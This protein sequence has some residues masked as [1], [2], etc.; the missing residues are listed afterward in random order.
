MLNST[1]NSRKHQFP[2]L[3]WGS[4]ITLDAL[5]FEDTLEDTWCPN[6]SILCSRRSSWAA[7]EPMEL[8]LTSC[9][10]RSGIFETAN[11]STLLVDG[12]LVSPDIRMVL[13]AGMED[14]SGV[15]DLVR[16]VEEDADVRKGEGFRFYGVSEPRS[17]P[18]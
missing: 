8:R 1:S 12:S 18:R 15:G 4:S 11:Y 14:V 17:N 6:L 16:E 5:R 7:K 2:C 9:M 3:S 13:I 10:I